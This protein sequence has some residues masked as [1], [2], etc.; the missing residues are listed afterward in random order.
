MDVAVAHAHAHH[1]VIAFDADAGDNAVISYSIVSDRSSDR[2][3]IHPRT[4]VIY[5]QKE[6]I[7]G[8]SFDLLVSEC[9]VK[10]VYVLYNC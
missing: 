3:K 2:F 8:M 5:S 1:R 9:Q 10:V 6:F 7:K 4:G